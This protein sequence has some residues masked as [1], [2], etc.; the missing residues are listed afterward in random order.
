MPIE[1]VGDMDQQEI[2]ELF[3]S[4][5]NQHFRILPPPL[6]LTIQLAFKAMMVLLREWSVLR[7]I[8]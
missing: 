6:R 3:G 2:S 1:I 5:I 4:V 7:R 8:W